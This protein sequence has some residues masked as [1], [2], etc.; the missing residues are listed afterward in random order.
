M[1]CISDS[2]SRLPAVPP[3][4]TPLLLLVNLSP[5]QSLSSSPPQ[6][7]QKAQ[8]RA[9]KNLADPSS[10]K[11]AR[12]WGALS[13]SRPA[14]AHSP[15]PGPEASGRSEGQGVNSGVSWRLSLPF[16]MGVF[17]VGAVW[18]PDDPVG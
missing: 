8:N 1:A 4:P 18:S 7:S 14:S 2:F 10:G 15:L 3:T 13:P 17:G 11:L 12:L 5:D 16:G 6:H 9:E